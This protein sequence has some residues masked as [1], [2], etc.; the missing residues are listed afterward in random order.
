MSDIDDRVSQLR[1]RLE[2]GAMSRNKLLQLTGAN[3]ERLTKEIEILEGRRNTD[4]EVA[5][6]TEAILTQARLDAAGCSTEVSKKLSDAFKL[7]LP[8]FVQLVDNT[9]QVST[10]FSTAKAV[11]QATQNMPVTSAI[12]IFDAVTKLAI[13]GDYVVNNGFTIGREV[14]FKNQ[15]NTLTTV[16]NN[17]AIAVKSL[18]PAEK[19]YENISLLQDLSPDSKTEV[20]KVAVVAAVKPEDI[21]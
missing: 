4:L 11:I 20:E 5:K 19:T 8:L 9:T 10:I 7:T 15:M 14:T 13:A 16:Y 3:M 17:T 6:N 21:F 2:Q 12:S 1:N 18:P